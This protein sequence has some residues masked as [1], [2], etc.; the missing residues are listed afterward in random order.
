MR[1]EDPFETPKPRCRGVSRFRGSRFSSIA[2]G[3]HFPPLLT[4][5]PSPTRGT[6]FREVGPNSLM[7]RSVASFA[8]AIPYSINWLPSPEQS[9]AWDLD[10]LFAVVPF[11]DRS[12]HRWP[13]GPVPRVGLTSSLTPSIERRRGSP[14]RGTTTQATDPA[15]TTGVVQGSRS[16]A[17]TVYRPHLRRLTMSTQSHAWDSEGLSQGVGIATPC[18][19]L[20][21]PVPR[22]GLKFQHAPSRAVVGAVGRPGPLAQRLLPPMPRHHHSVGRRSHASRRPFESLTGLLPRSPESVPR[23]G[24]HCS[25][26]GGGHT[27]GGPTHLFRTS[28]TRGTDFQFA[29]VLSRPL[30]SLLAPPRRPPRPVPRD[31]GLSP[32]I[33]FGRARYHPCLTRPVPRVGLGARRSFSCRP[34]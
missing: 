33:R 12:I 31:F 1:P 18:T 4:T 19:G 9:H 20:A 13:L 34:K 15:G 2:Q 28:P 7:L 11:P 8:G 21:D 27:P 23:V 25:S 5:S 26:Q 3:G 24:L 29:R 22:V 30:R 10:R 17:R 6:S 32:R 14:T 16:S